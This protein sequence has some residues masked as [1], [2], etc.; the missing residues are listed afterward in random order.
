MVGTSVIRSCETRS[1]RIIR[2]RALSFLFN[3]N[4][5]RLPLQ[6]K[7]RN[8]SFDWSISRDRP[9][10]TTVWVARRRPCE[11]RHSATIRQRPTV[12]SISSRSF[13][14]ERSCSRRKPWAAEFPTALMGT[15]IF[16]WSFNSNMSQ[17]KIILD[18][19]PDSE[20]PPTST[21]IKAIICRNWPILSNT[22]SKTSKLWTGAKLKS[23]M[24]T[25]TAWKAP[26]NTSSWTIRAPK[27]TESALDSAAAPK[28][29][30]ALL[31]RRHSRASPRHRPHGSSSDQTSPILQA[32]T[33]S[34]WSHW[35]AAPMATTWARRIKEKSTHRW[36]TPCKP[37]RP[38]Q[39]QAPKY[40]QLKTPDFWISLE[41]K[42]EYRTQASKPSRRRG[43]HLW[44][45]VS[46]QE[47]TDF[48]RAPSNCSPT[49]RA[50]SRRTRWA[51]T[52][53]VLPST[54]RCKSS[55]PQISDKM[56]SSNH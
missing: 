53:Q 25:T 35:T 46:N 36:T 9:P 10:Q 21:A 19:A 18:P 26:S 51:T 56:E 11:R 43:K 38:F 3:R 42:A 41:A 6:T 54:G 52:E 1:S 29:T 8:R 23:T 34:T 5:L 37:Q 16:E 39:M 13:S 44:S 47:S 17:T 30:W 20:W 2:I 32:P 24:R 33:R 14:K 28:R 31:T 49:L 50:I 12:P 22:V 45:A 4:N 55:A 48:H 27:T 15:M 40:R 7:D